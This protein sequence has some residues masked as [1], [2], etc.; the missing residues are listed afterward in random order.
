MLLWISEPPP[1]HA[2]CAVLHPSVLLSLTCLRC[3]SQ[4][5]LAFLSTMMSEKLLSPSVPIPLL[6]ALSLPSSPPYP[7]Y[8]PL[9]FALS[10]P[11]SPPCS[12]S[13]LLSSLL[14][15]Y[16]PLLP[17]LSPPLLSSL[18]SLHPSSPPCSLHP[19]LFSLSI[20]NWMRSSTTLRC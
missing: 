20:V 10:L 18:L 2:V 5:R 7:L 1:S 3:L 6:P 15:L 17:A 12:L 4:V 8:P 19:P 11:S 9:I 13:T 16:P 14:S